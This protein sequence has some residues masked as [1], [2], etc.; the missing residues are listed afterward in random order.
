MAI[1]W[2]LK[3]MPLETPS[4]R[5]ALQRQLL[6]CQNVFFGIDGWEGVVKTC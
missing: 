6:P 1:I 2:G 5:A 3:L 4:I